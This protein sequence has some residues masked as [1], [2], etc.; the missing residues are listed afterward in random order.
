MCFGE[1]K[2][3]LFSLRLAC[4]KIGGKEGV[5][6]MRKHLSRLAL[7]FLCGIVVGLFGVLAFHQTQGDRIARQGFSSQAVLVL[8]RDT[9]RRVFSFGDQD[10]LAPASLVKLMTCLVV[11]DRQPDLGAPA[12][13]LPEAKAMAHD[14]YA[15][16]SGLVPE[17]KT[18]YRDLLYATMLASDGAAA[19]SL[20]INLAG[21]EER[22]V[23]WMNRKALR[24]GLFR[25]HF[26]DPIGFDHPDQKTTARDMARLL[27]KALRDPDFYALFTGPCY[28]VGPSSVHP[29][30]V[31]IWSTVIGP[32]QAAAPPDLEILGGKSGTTQEAGLCWATLGQKQEKDYICIVLGAPLGTQ[33]QV[34]DTMAAYAKV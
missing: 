20:A 28:K 5:S 1:T 29:Q 10:K 9:G 18:T 3:S 23:G 8:D 19:Q 15:S 33:D 24:M 7:L 11:L 32:G 27:D 17:D 31:D 25:T 14:R 4:G 26:T 21:S 16:Q 13:L 34:R 30:G 6:F 22:F 2:E 12:P